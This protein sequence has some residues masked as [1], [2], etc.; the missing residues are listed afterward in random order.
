[1][2]FI[3][4]LRKGTAKLVSGST[5]V[6][7][8]PGEL[9]YIPEGEPYQS[10]WYGDDRGDIE[11]DSFGFLL[12]PGAD[13]KMY[14]LQK[15]PV[16]GQ[17]MALVDAIAGSRQVCCASLGDLYHLLAL[18]M[19]H[20]AST[21]RHEERRIL[22]EAENYLWEHPQARM[23]EVAKYCGISESGLYS[24]FSREG[25]QTPNG[26][27]QQI[28]AKKA[29]ELLQTTDM[30]VEDVSSRLGFSSSSYFRKVLKKHTGM[31]PRELRKQAKWW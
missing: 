17:I 1:M 16:D 6:Q 3:G 27:R 29:A 31:T 26:L 30:S 11:F 4:L 13:L 23:A 8:K 15:L 19:P 18:L 9:F 20:M 21:S 5:V 2:H 22:T 7:V 28:L 10:Y 12:F 14:A 25:G 24:T